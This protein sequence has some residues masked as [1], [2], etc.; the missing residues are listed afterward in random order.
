M[1][2]G[3]KIGPVVLLIA[4]KDAFCDSHAMI[5]RAPWVV[6]RSLRLHRNGAIHVGRSAKVVV[7]EDSILMP[8]LVNAHCHLDYTDL[9]G[10]ILPRKSFTAWIEQINAA[11]HS[12]SP[13]DFTR[14]IARGLAESLRYGTTA[15]VNWICSPSTLPVPPAVPMR[16]WHLWE[17]IAIR[18]PVDVSAWDEW[19]AT[20]QGRSPLWHGGVAPHALY[21]CVAE[22]VAEAARWSARH[23]LPWSIHLAESDE[24]FAMFHDARGPLFEFF[25][26]LG[27]DLRDCGGTSPLRALRPELAS[28]RSPLLLVHA[29]G[30]DRGDFRCLRAWPDAIRRRLHVVHCPRSHAFLAHP[31]F[32]LKSLA[33]SG[34]NLCLGTDSLASNTNLSMFE[35]MGACRAAHPELAAD[36]VVRMATLN[37]AAALGQSR[38]WPRWDDWIAIRAAAARPAAVWEAICRFTGEPRFVMVDG[39]VLH[40]K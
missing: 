12:W 10:S 11:K 26:R 25:R 23:R 6:D 19:R 30:L 15:L 5:L 7:L 32:P 35:E 29:N 28:L 9:R 16:V 27:R 36:E 22:T 39:K 3:G 17:Q 21:S 31:S 40:S 20:I 13:G 14:S 18:S 8:G 24:E 4:A 2:T 38:A 33:R 1:L 37:G 34:I